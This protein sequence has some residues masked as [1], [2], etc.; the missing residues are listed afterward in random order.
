MNGLIRCGIRGAWCGNLWKSRATSPVL[1]LWQREAGDRHYPGRQESVWTPAGRSLCNNELCLAEGLFA[2]TS[3]KDVC[4]TLRVWA[5]GLPG[6]SLAAQDLWFPIFKGWGGNSFQIPHIWGRGGSGI[7]AELEEAADTLTSFLRTPRTWARKP[8]LLLEQPQIW[9]LGFSF[10][11]FSV[12]GHL[13]LECHAGYSQHCWGLVT[14]LELL[15]YREEPADVP[16]LATVGRT[17]PLVGFSWTLGNGGRWVE[18]TQAV[19]GPRP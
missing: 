3:L 10:L 13:L 17:L 1:I 15:F 12:P 4:T 2:C 14:W 18:V 6:C 16:V 5:L 11:F 19:T 8:G 7:Q 9:I